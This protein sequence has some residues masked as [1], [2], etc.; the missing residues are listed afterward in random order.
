MKASLSI[1][2]STLLALALSA[3]SSLPVST[4]PATE[5]RNGRWFDGTQFV[6]KTMWVVGEAFAES[7]PAGVAAVI[8][9]HDGFAVPPYGEGHNHWLEP[10]LV[11]AYVQTYLRD[12]IFYVKDQSTPPQFH[13]QMRA[14]LGGPA[15]VD[16]I[17]AHQ[18]FTG[19][20]GHPIEL[21]V[22]LARLG[23]LPAAWA[24]TH[25]EGDALFSVS[26]EQD[27]DRAWPKLMAG[28][29]DF[30]KVFLVHSD[31]YAARRDNAALSPKQRG[32]DPAL[33]PGIVARAHAERLRVS[34]HI[35]SAHDFHVAIAAGVD[36]I[37]HL[38]FVDSGNPEGD[39][40]AGDDLRAAAARGV[41]IAT[42]LDWMREATSDSQIQVARDNIA[43]I[44]RAGGTIVIGTDQFRKTARAE[45]ELLMSRHLMSNLELLQAW[46]VATPR[47]IFP[48]RKIGR[49]SKG[50][51]ASFLVLR[52]DPLADGANMQKIAMWVKR[53][54]AFTPGDTKLP[55]LGG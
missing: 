9:L 12:G 49:L 53:G 17:A 55:T 31:Q 29:P 39:R 34:A 1:S 38:P 5:Y 37:A 2:T 23:I 19:P 45:A 4:G 36:D 15:S 3:C 7:R 27:I 32:L 42:T 20:N 40:L 41:S 16:Y 11:D 43:G 22:Q 26:S 50:F 44:R 24:D 21:V 18:G 51:E 25:G 54:H 47:A 46:S 6:A 14:A 10:Q 48:Q 35:E 52:G 13:D 33:V 8:D 30:V 28:R